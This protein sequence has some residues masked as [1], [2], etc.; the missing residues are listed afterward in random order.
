M[1]EYVFI[2]VNDPGPR[3]TISENG[4]KLTIEKVCKDCEGQGD[5]RSDLM[6]VQCMARNIHNYTFADAYLNVLRKLPPHVTLTNS[7][8]G[9]VLRKLPPHVTLTIVTMLTC[10]V[11][12]PPHVTLT[13]VYYV[14]V[15]RKLPPQVT[16]TIVTMAMCCVSY[17]LMSL[18]Q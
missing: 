13:I 7:Y 10:C 1:C 12:L 18:Q 14:N 15:L 9:N 8:Y 16:L 11:R 5:H 6:N 3:R 4:L 17:L 2:A